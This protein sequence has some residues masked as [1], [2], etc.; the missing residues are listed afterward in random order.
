MSETMTTQMDTVLTLL[1]RLSPREQ[2]RVVAQVL[3]EVERKLETPAPIAGDAD[4]LSAAETRF[5]QMLLEQGLLTEIKKPLQ[6]PV[7]VERLAPVT[8]EGVP[9]S[10]MII[11]ERR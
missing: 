7:P 9:L 10:E 2:L 4:T 6:Y 3:P 8:V 11:A 1:R 5:K